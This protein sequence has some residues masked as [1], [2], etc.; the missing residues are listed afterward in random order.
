LEKLYES[1]RIKAIGVDNFTQNRMK[2]NLDI[3]DFVLTEDEMNYILKPDTGHSCFPAVFLLQY[4][5]LY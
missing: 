1:G 3:F 4:C 2:E 5:P